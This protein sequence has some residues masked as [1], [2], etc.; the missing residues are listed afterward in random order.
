MGQI[1]SFAAAQQKRARAAVLDRFEQALTR[2]P[3]EDRGLI[4]FLADEYGFDA[5]MIVIESQYQGTMH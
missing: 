3:E 2:V 1:C 5:M 4:L